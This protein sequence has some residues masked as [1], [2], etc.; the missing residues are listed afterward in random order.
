M[1]SVVLQDDYKVQNWLPHGTGILIQFP[2]CPSL[3]T[4]PPICDSLFFCILSIALFFW[5]LFVV[6]NRCSV[7]IWAIENSNR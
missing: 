7:M 6:E 2:P 3:K 1:T 4:T 5:A